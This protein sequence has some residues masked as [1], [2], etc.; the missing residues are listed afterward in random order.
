MPECPHGCDWEEIRSDS[1]LKIYFW[2]SV[3]GALRL[4]RP[5]QNKASEVRYPSGVPITRQE[6]MRGC[7]K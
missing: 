3:C 7:L 1:I 4:D 5:N 6:R 2:C